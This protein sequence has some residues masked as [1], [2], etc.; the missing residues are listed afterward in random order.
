MHD[1]NRLFVDLKPPAGGL[2]RL[3][4]SLSTLH[5]GTL[6][7]GTHQRGLRLAAGVVLAM[8]VLMTIWQLP[9]V[10]VRQQQ[11]AALTSALHVAIAPPAHGIQVTDGA[12]LELPSN[13][14][15]VR[16]YLVQS[17]GSQAP[18]GNH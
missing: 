18:A 4:G 15:N 14:P 7:H 16:L 10:I 3:Q 6:H 5:H 13:D 8:S 1:S 17:A 12:A 11:T 2:Q 9:G